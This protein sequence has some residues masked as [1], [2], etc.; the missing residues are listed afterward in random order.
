M[1]VHVPP[2]KLWDF[3]AENR[4]KL[5]DNYMLIAEESESLVEVYLTEERG[6]P[7]RKSVV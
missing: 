6:F 1:T 2:E 3:F 7:D 4:Q 5:S